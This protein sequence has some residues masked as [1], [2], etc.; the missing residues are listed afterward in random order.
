MSD[1]LN[2]AI[3]VAAV[4]MASNVVKNI[5]GALASL[6]SGNVTAAASAAGAVLLGVGAAAV[7]VGV[8]ATKMAGD[9]QEGLTSLV[10][11]AGEAQANLKAVGD[12][13][14]DL[15]VKTATST[16]QLT[17]GMYLI[18][19]SG[20]HGADGLKVLQAAAEGAKVGSADLGVTANA[21]TTI[22]TDYHL[23]ATEAASATNALI[24]TVASGKTHLQDLASSMGSVLP[25]AS[26]LGISFPQVGG[27]IATM[28]NAG[29]G[30]QQASQ[31]LANTI[32][33][34][35]APNAAAEKSMKA[36]GL[37]AQDLK[38]TLQ[39]QG[40]SAAL[41]MV[42]DHVGSKFPAGSVEAVN[43]F[44]H[45]VGGA[46][47]YNVALMLGGQN[48]KTF[49]GN[50][51][52]IGKAMKSGGDSVQGWSLVQKD[53]N[54][55]VGQAQQALNALLIKV[56]SALLPV[57]SQLMAQVT[58][59]ISQFSEWAT[60]H[61]VLEAVASALTA[62]IS[63][64]SQVIVTVAR[65]IASLVSAIVQIVAF[66]QHSQ[67]ATDA[68][69]AALA[70][71]AAGLAIYLATLLPA[72][73]ASFWTWA[74]AAGAAAVATLAAIWP[75]VAIG[76]A[77][78]LV[79]FAI[80]MAVQHWGDIIKWL[81]TV[82]AAFSAWFQDAMH[83]VGAFFINI[84]HG[85]QQAMQ[86]AWN[87]IVNAA[88]IAVAVLLIV[89]F[90]PILAIAALFVWLYQHNIY[91]QML[92]DAIVA[93][94]KIAI[95]WLMSAWQSAVDWIVAA[96][97]FLS[98]ATTRGW[99]TITTAIMVAVQIVWSW[100]VAIW[101]TISSWISDKWNSFADLAKTAW[102]AVAS[103]FSA[104]WTTYLSKPLGDLW[105]SISTWFSSLAT[106][107]TT[108]GTNLIQGFINGIKNM[109]S[110]VGQ[111]ASDIAG[112][113][114]SFLGF[115][116]PAKEGPGSELM[117]WGPGL[118]SGFS[119]SV[120]SALPIL[121]ATMQVTA[122]HVAVLG[123]PGAS[124]VTTSGGTA[125]LSGG[126]SGTVINITVNAPAR[127]RNEANEIADMVLD[128]LSRELRRSGNLVTVTSGGRS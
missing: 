92:C 67:V 117:T 16:K 98:D 84:W 107:A 78:A 104:I 25:L 29:M 126:G 48:M 57:L 33:S 118:I 17:D 20:I 114:A 74:V 6:G 4:D 112:K 96:W 39:N 10:T 38:D 119:E 5:G 62:T 31:N 115:H 94:V 66:F 95:A 47:G 122:Q 100:L 54:F 18:E 86:A 50:V 34:L 3:N 87:F 105:T 52:S 9:F 99:A 32:R 89:L 60:Q 82:W 125:A 63:V 64:L 102:S 2:L 61:H 103:V 49:E 108:W 81:Q 51:D 23:P 79:V 41:Q 40:L 28:T 1:N 68:L 85:I 69:L 71:L 53:F 111:A 43:A 120:K 8:Q 124:G 42:E 83:A 22:L 46:T 106:S 90:G 56:G 101:T 19:S 70:G 14:L 13:I 59:L 77:V 44:K 58:P 37:S 27:A 91:F 21:V 35:A 123:Q 127:T 24:T 30:A 11:G 93:A 76:A 121:D 45:I 75:F 72:L 113:V 36:V 116:S 7:G 97:T 80:I 65:D 128:K 55:Q 26:S 12:G 88:K 109:A 110:N 73:I 15:S